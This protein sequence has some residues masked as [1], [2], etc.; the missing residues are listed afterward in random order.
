MQLPCQDGKSGQL[1]NLEIWQLEQV[2]RPVNRV[3]TPGPHKLAID[4]P[5]I[6]KMTLFQYVKVNQAGVKNS[7]GQTILPSQIPTRSLVHALRRADPGDLRPSDA[8]ARR[9]VAARACQPP[10]SGHL[11]LSDCIEGG[12]EDRED[13]PPHGPRGGRVRYVRCSASLTPRNA[14]GGSVV[15]DRV[16]TFFKGPQLPQAN[17]SGARLSSPGRGPQLGGSGNDAA[18]VSFS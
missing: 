5:E 14:A 11:A 8:G 13:G 6:Q 17:P 4:R 7:D 3:D 16:A 9:P 1:R 15:P 18:A 2:R 10:V 12:E